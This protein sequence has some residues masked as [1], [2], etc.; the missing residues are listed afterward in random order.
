MKP[1][2][3][4]INIVCILIS[5]ACIALT[6]WGNYKNN[7]VLTT[8]AFIGICTTLIGVCATIIV[9]FQIASFFKIQENEKQL[10]QLKVERDEIQ[11]AQINIQDKIEFL[12]A[13]LSNAFVTIAS[14]TETNAIKSIA[15]L[16]AIYCNKI[17]DTN[18]EITLNRYNALLKSLKDSSEKERASLST[19]LSKFNTIKIPESVEH[20]TTIMKLHFE[21]IDILEKAAKEHND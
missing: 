12:G 19:Q 8:D 9:G 16:T 7:G 4:I 2:N 3:I 5:L 6:F 21:V 1:C 11:K 17:K 15:Y 10:E 13:N 18:A 14:I 20:Y